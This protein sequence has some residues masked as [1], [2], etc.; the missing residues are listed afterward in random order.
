MIVTTIEGA[1]KGMSEMGWA[2]FCLD[3]LRGVYGDPYDPEACDP[4]E[5]LCI[6]KMQAARWE[7]TAS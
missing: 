6:D 3:S 2:R 7:Y 1:R 4:E 5:E